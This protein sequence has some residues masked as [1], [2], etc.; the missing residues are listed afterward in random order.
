MAAIAVAAFNL[1]IQNGFL[2]VDF[3][4]QNIGSDHATNLPLSI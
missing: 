2:R 3:A 4:M 1:L